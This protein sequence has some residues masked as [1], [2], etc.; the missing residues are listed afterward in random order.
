M[1]RPHSKSVR[2]L[3]L[4]TSR[5]KEALPINAIVNRGDRADGDNCRMPA[6]F[7]YAEGRF[8]G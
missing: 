5:H 4:Q 6:S 2:V 3:G 7:S 8:R 1:M